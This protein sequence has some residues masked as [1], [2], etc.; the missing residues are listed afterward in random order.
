MIALL[1]ERLTCT[2]T[3]LT[4]ITSPVGFASARL[5]PLP[6]LLP[7]SISASWS[8]HGLSTATLTLS[9]PLLQWCGKLRPAATM[10]GKGIKGV[11]APV[12]CLTSRPGSWKQLRSWFRRKARPHGECTSVVPT[13]VTG[14]SLQRVQPWFSGCERLDVA[15]VEAQVPAL[16]PV[17]RLSPAVS[18]ALS[19]LI[20]R[21]DVPTARVPPFRKPS[22]L[23]ALKPCLTLRPSKPKRSVSFAPNELVQEYTPWNF[24][25]QSPIH[26]RLVGPPYERSQK[27]VKFRKEWLL[28]PVE[29]YLEPD[30]HNQLNFPRTKWIRDVPTW[31][32]VDADG[33]VD[34][35]DV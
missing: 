31:E 19:P 3:M 32:D 5:A 16:S 20:P 30:G 26:T 4:L 9:A 18:E 12:F 35:V 34:M 24:K 6:S 15:K 28:S 8:S 21:V 27:R 14:E 25:G 29:R 23:A 2:C 13:S 1:H 17:S 33:D 7:P 10:A 11:H 22:V